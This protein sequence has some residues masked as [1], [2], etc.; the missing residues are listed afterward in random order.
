MSEDFL[1][2]RKKGLEDAFFAEQ[3]ALLRRRLREA[4]E[5]GSRRKALSSASGITD[6]ATLER[7]EALGITGETAAALSLIPLVAIA[8][9]DGRIE[10]RER[11]AALSGA[12]GLG[13]TK[14]DPGYQMFEGWLTRQPSPDLLMSWKAYIGA[15]VP[16]LG[17]DARDALRGA[18]LGHARA[19]AEAAG[20]FLGL[21]S[22][23]SEAEQSVLAD[24]ERAFA[25]SSP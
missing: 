20:G 1:A 13:L 21:G 11:A 18:L 19:V 24:L 7:L 10:E 15:L 22:K 3:D 16:T 25:A 12:E 9:A 23:I 5:T 8:W 4:D 14:G 2:G 17:Q 6:H